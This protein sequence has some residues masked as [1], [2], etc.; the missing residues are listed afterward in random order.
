MIMINASNLH[1]GLLNKELRDYLSLAIVKNFAEDNA[2]YEYQKSSAPVYSAYARRE[3]DYNIAVLEHE[4]SCKQ[5]FLEVK[6]NLSAIIQLMK[7][8]GWEDYDVSDLVSK[9]ARYSMC[10]NFIGTAEEHEAFQKR[11]AD[12]R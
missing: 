11:L 12:E 5:R 1:D 4:I 2:V 9:Q 8:N 7:M 6:R 10:H 3:I